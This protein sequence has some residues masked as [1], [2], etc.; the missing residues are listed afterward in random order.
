MLNLDALSSDEI[1]LIGKCLSAAANGPFFPDEEFG[2]I[3]GLTRDEVRN[4]ALFWPA[5]P[6]RE[7]ERAV[8]GSLNNLSGYPH[9]E[10][11]AL[12]AMTSSTRSKI[13][14][15]LTKLSSGEAR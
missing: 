8:V 4:A 11:G 15:V 14:D 2:T 13:R 10:D 6:S 3:F 5:V 12:L 9:A 1:A 7:A